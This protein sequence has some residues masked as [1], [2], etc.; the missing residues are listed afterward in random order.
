MK[1]TFND[2]PLVI[3]IKPKF[4]A[5]IY[6]G[7]KTIELRRVLPRNWTG[8]LVFIYESAPV[9][10]I[11]GSFHCYSTLRMKKELFWINFGEK[12]GISVDEFFQ[13][14]NGLEYAQGLFIHEATRYEFNMPLSNLQLK[15]PP[16]NFC[17][18]ANK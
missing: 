14:F 11:T 15:K 4:A 16:Q 2:K 13:Y 17:Y 5:A 9:S 6:S 12:T 3:S 10:S 18:A 8:S 1:M 7:V